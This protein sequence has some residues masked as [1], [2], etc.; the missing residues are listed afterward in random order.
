MDDLGGKTENP[1]P[2]YFGKHPYLALGILDHLMRMMSWNLSNV[3]QD[4]WGWGNIHLP[5]FRGKWRFF[6][7]SPTQNAPILMVTVTGRTYIPFG[8]L[9][10]NH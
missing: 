1:K 4:P 7:E 6:W 5:V 10:T 9:S 8:D 3:S 2:H